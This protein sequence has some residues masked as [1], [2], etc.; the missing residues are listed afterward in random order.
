MLVLGGGKTKTIIACEN[1]GYSIFVKK[2]IWKESN[3]HRGMQ[4]ENIV[5]PVHTIQYTHRSSSN[6]PGFNLD[7]FGLDII[8]AMKALP[9]NLLGDVCTC[10]KTRDIKM[11]SPFSE[12][13]L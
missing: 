2:N 11:T 4:H 9:M 1:Q 6:L 7:L 12:W 8:N 10:N 13:M 5:Q 3:S